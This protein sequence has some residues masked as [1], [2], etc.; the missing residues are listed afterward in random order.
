MSKKREW[1]SLDDAVKL[2]MKRTGKNREEATKELLDSLQSGKT[3]A[4]AF[5]LETGESL[6]PITP[7]RRH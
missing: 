2:I 6:G 3:A 1:M 5:D 4:R 7:L